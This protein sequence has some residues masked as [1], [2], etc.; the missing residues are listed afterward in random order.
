MQNRLF[1]IL[2]MHRSG[3]SLLT[4]LCNLCGLEL[5][6]GELVPPLPNDNETGFW[7]LQYIVDLNEELLTEHGITHLDPT[8]LPS[9][10]HH[11]SRALT[12]RQEATAFLKQAIKSSSLLAIKDP[13]L[14]RTLPFWL[15]ICDELSITPSA[16][17]SVRHPMEVAMSLHRRNHISH[18][19]G[20]ELWQIYNQEALEH[21]KHLERCFVRFPDITHYHEWHLNYIAQA[22]DFS[23]PHPPKTIRNEL[24][25]FIRPDLHHNR[26]QD[27][28]NTDLPPEILTLYTQLKDYC[29]TPPG[30]Y[31]AYH[32][33][34]RQ[35]IR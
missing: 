14:C 17:Y 34:I 22:L 31:R 28:K 10:W 18:Q 19:Q 7:E 30:L 8:S 2:G 25:D 16:I 15:D 20:L 23:W 3:T 35:H 6:V 26:H 5:E 21:S 12:L 11:T 9:G 13:R 4:R 24:H 27:T 32:N 29:K 1:F 33:F